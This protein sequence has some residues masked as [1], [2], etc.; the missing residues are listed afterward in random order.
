MFDGISAGE[1][2]SAAPE[3]LSTNLLWWKGRSFV[4]SHP[5]AK[6][7][8]GWG[9]GHSWEKKS[10][11]FLVCGQVLR[12]EYMQL[13]NVG[14]ELIKR[15]EGFRAHTY[16]D[17]AGLATIGYGHRLT[18]PGLYPNGITEEQATEI[19]RADVQDALGSVERLVKVPLSQNQVDALVDFVFNLGQERFARSTLLRALNG[20]RYQAAGE[21]LLRWDLIAGQ[22]NLGLRARRLAEL[23]L[24]NAP[25]AASE[26]A[27]PAKS[28]ASAVPA[29]AVQ[30]GGREKAA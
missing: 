2:A 23:A 1:S 30:S 20:G 14:L 19:L 9:T 16:L 6:Y 21:Q 3:E 7:A 24:W 11:V 22:E 8:K 4:A 26:P 27:A 13:S 25:A 28:A 17:P 12:E 15:F 29:P 10:L 5:F 18:E